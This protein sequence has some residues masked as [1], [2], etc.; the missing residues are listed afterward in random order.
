MGGAERNEMIHELVMFLLIRVELRNHVKFL[1][2]PMKQEK[3]EKKVETINFK[4]I[5]VSFLP[6]ETALPSYQIRLLTYNFLRNIT[7]K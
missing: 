7:E 3:A 6:L 2:F 5:I 1:L 4:L